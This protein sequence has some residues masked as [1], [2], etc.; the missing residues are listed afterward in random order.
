[1][2][3]VLRQALHVLWRRCVCVKGI[4]SLLVGQIKM[5][6]DEGTAE[7]GFN[8][9]AVVLPL[10]CLLAGIIKERIVQQHNQVRFQ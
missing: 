5:E 9:R 1:M 6:C 2:Q 7:Q 4:V 8:R 10:A 3:L